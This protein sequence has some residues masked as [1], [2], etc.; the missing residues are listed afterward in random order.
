MLKYKNMG[1]ITHA[2]FAHN[3]GD[4]FNFYTVT[5]DERLFVQKI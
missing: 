1:K 5:L 2:E 3:V 4:L